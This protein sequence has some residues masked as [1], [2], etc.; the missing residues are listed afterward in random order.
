MKKF[1][2]FFTLLL[3]LLVFKGYS[4]HISGYDM[5]MVHLTGDTYKV[6]V[7]LYRDANPNSPALPT[8]L[9][10]STYDRSNDSDV[11]L[12]ISLPRVSMYFQSYEAS[13]CAPSTSNLSLQVG[14]YEYT[15]LASQALSLSSPLGYYFSS[16]TCCRSSAINIFIAESQGYNF[17]MDFPAL[18]TN[19]QF[20]YNSSPSFPRAPLTTFCIGKPTTINWQCTD[21]DGDSL[22][23]SIVPSWD[24]V[25]SAKPFTATTF[26][27]GYNLYYNIMDGNP[28]ISIHPITGDINFTASMLGKYYLMI[29]VK[30]FRKINGVDHLIGTT[31]REVLFNTIACVETP[32]VLSSLHLNNHVIRDTIPLSIYDST[33]T[34]NRI[35]VGSDIPQDSILMKIIPDQGLGNNVFNKN[36]GFGEIGYLE[37]GTAGEQNEIISMGIIQGKFRWMMDSTMARNTP[38]HFKVFLR[39]QTCPNYF[40]DIIDVYIYAPKKNCETIH[41]E[42]YVSGCDSAQDDKGKWY[43]VSGLYWDVYTNS[44]GC[45][46]ITKYNVKLSET[47]VTQN[48]EGCDSVLGPNNKYYYSTGIYTDTVNTASCDT[49]YHSN[50]IIMSSPP[51]QSIVGDA[52]VSAGTI[53][54]YFITP[55]PLSAVLWNVNNGKLISSNRFMATIEWGNSNDASINVIELSVNGCS[56]VNN[57]DVDILG[58]GINTQKS[59]FKIYP[60]PTNGKIWIENKSTLNELNADIF[61][62]QGSKLKSFMLLESNEIDISEYVKGVYFIKIEGA[63]FKVLKY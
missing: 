19:S 44:S 15:L 42:V 63:V 7:R 24:G 22:S 52:S 10:F 25:N 21:A 49:I 48:L 11:G 41:R 5:N 26:A 3:C 38:Y 18:S 35:F 31:Y 27:P 39:D 34:Y 51:K 55:L 40:S 47:N 1:R 61:D 8:L 29:K 58:V 59:D 12:N 16:T 36:A 37:Y 6:K 60:N 30:E 54:Q 32:P 23:Y 57:L 14:E 28:D 50:V 46:V 62:I 43:Y 2:H 45:E 53:H 4:T 9:T 20:K 17:T 56:T 33:Y 13:D